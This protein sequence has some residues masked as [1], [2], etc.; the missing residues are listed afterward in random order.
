MRLICNGVALDLM[1]DATLSFKKENPLFAFDNLSCE[2][3]QSFEIPGTAN[4]ERILQ[5]AKVPAFRGE[6]MRRRYECEM[7]NGTVVKRGYLYVDAYEK[8]RYNAIFVT[9]ELF[10]LLRIR[11]AGTIADI[12]ADD[13]STKWG[14]PITAD[15]ARQL[16]PTW[17]CVQY[18]QTFPNGVP[19]PS[20]SLKKVLDKAFNNIGV[21]PPTLPQS[22]GEIRVIPGKLNKIDTTTAITSEPKANSQSGDPM[23]SI[24][25]DRRY[26]DE[27]SIAYSN[28]MTGVCSSFSA[29][30]PQDQWRTVHYL[31]VRPTDTAEVQRTIK[32]VRARFK[33]QITFP[34]DDRLNGI[35]VFRKDLMTAPYDLGNFYQTQA[36]EYGWGFQYE[37]SALTNTDY[38]M[39][40]GRETVEDVDT[41]NIARTLGIAVKGATINVEAG[42]VIAFIRIS[43]LQSTQTYQ[44]QSGATR[45]AR[46]E[47]TYNNGQSNYE[48]EG[49]RGFDLPMSILSAEPDVEQRV[50]L[51]P[52]LPELTITDALKTLA[53]MYGRVINYTDAQGITLETLS[54]IQR[55]AQIRIDGK[56][57]ECE[58]LTRSFM[59]YAQHNT[60]EFDSYGNIYQ[61][62]RVIIDYEIDNDNIAE[63]RNMQTLPFSEGSESLQDQNTYRAVLIRN[64]DKQEIDKN[65]ITRAGFRDDNLGRVGLMKNAVIQTLCEQSTSLTVS[66]RMTLTEYEAM[67]AK[68][69][70]LYDGTRYVWTEA[71]WQKNV[72]KA[73]I[74]KI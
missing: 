56:V 60:V 48:R 22:A 69:L 63:S 21:T 5:L 45:M 23:N 68:T 49:M 29:Y 67:S 57:M 66:I 16:A 24:Y 52:N 20:Y 31:E 34:N 1:E 65:T 38:A 37:G 2:R 17:R 32:C 18:L 44:W 43:D 39:L 41:W 27:A 74:A 9:G 71:T 25:F 36:P 11:Q 15:M 51:Q 59:D 53:H 47:F 6:G 12:V 3:T 7:Q 4:N 33:M 61:S 64:T 28:G 73:K 55:W 46:F 54:D 10:G 50:Y 62:E 30:D 26:F 19:Y 8:N 14:D 72:C 35:I 40:S 58:K 70:L 42:D 13:A